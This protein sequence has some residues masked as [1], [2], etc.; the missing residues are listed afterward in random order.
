MTTYYV[1]DNPQNTPSKEH[2]VHTAGCSWLSL[3]TNKSY[4]G[5]FSS[6]KEAVAAAKRKYSS[7]D[8]CKHCS[9]ACHTR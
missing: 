8:G 7:V 2:E 4:L 3:A 6:C 9:P 1:N 5:E